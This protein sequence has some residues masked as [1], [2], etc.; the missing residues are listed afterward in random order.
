MPLSRVREAYFSC[1]ILQI[2]LFLGLTFANSENPHGS[3][4]ISCNMCHTT[5]S[6]E[7]LRPDIQ[8]D[9]QFQTDFPLDGKHL[10]VDCNE[11]HVSTVFSEV[12]TN[13]SSCHLD[14]HENQFDDN[15]QTCHSTDTWID[16]SEMV[17]FHDETSFPLTGVHAGL[18]CQI[19]H[20]DGN[21]VNVPLSCEG[22]HIAAFVNTD[23]PDHQSAGF[24]ADC[25]ICHSV[26]IQDWATP[27]YDHP[28]AFTLEQGHRDPDCIACHAAGTSYTLT[29]NECFSCHNQLFYAVDDPNHSAGN[30]NHDCQLCHSIGGWQPAEYD[31]NLSSFSLTGAHMA[32]ECA[33]CHLQNRFSG[34]PEHCYACHRAD[35]AAVVVPNHAA[36]DMGLDCQQ[37]HNTT[38]WRP[39]SF[40]H[41]QTEFVIDG[42]HVRLDCKLCHAGQ[43]YADTPQE[44]YG[45]HRTDFD[46]AAEPDHVLNQ[47]NQNCLICHTTSVWIPSTLDHAQTNFPLT[48]AHITADCAEC[49]V[50]DQY[51]GTPVDCWS[52]HQPAYKESTEPNHDEGM[53]DQDCAAC[54]TTEAWTPSTFNHDDTDYPLA[55]AHQTVDCNQCHLAGK[56]VGTP[57]DCYT[58]HQADYDNIADP[59]HS[60]PVFSHDCLACH[61]IDAW[62][63]AEFSH[64]GSEF[65]FNGGHEP[66]DCVSCHAG[67]SYN[68]TS[69]ECLACHQADFDE[70]G[71]PLH[72]VPEYDV[73]CLICHTIEA[74]TPA[75]FDHANS[76]FPLDGAHV[77]VDCASCHSNG[78]YNNTPATC[79][80]CH[81]EDFEEVSD[82]NHIDG[83]F[84]EDCL[85]CHNTSAWSPST[86][87]HDESDFQLTGAHIEATCAQCHI[88][89][90]FND[91]PSECYACH[92]ANYEQVV[93]PE[94]SEPQF[95]LDCAVCHT[96]T[97]WLTSTYDHNGSDF[98]LTG[99]HVDTDCAQ[100]HVNRQYDNTPADCYFCHQDAYERAEEPEH[101]QNQ[102]D[103][104]C[105]LCHS[106]EAWEPADFDH[107]DNDFPLTGAHTEVN[108]SDCHI[109][110][111]YNETPTDCYACHQEEYEDAND[112]DHESEGYPVDCLMCHATVDWDE[113][114]FDHDNDYFPIYRGGHRNRWDECNE[115]HVQEGNYEAFSCI[116]CHEHRREEA[117]DEHEDVRNYRYET[118]AC[119]ECHPNGEEDDDR[120][121]QLQP[122]KMKN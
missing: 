68:D 81:R 41:D 29:S 106:T 66:V 77:E 103:H 30:F 31:H 96:T 76:D 39:S 26:Q 50:Q 99:A 32:V 75:I 119:F 78:G 118:A 27:D 40:R 7:E 90:Q 60:E 5:D 34:T 61:T 22:C 54:H 80:G 122:M 9:H 70:V 82:P 73:N 105:K 28:D 102:F 62:N 74:W 58:C 89:G 3:L 107:D 72:T 104:D 71:D 97:D 86:F 100:C 115:C 117:D 109:A 67:G 8:F 121:F 48:G 36:S 110:G 114:N 45:C 87:D 43:T 52:C 84:D 13:C 69:V 44:C 116:D 35:Y 108:C 4:D 101:N 98:V 112:P 83:Q 42:S 57:N 46:A 25:S 94:H 18:D 24:E 47:L 91:L 49:H 51:S 17:L 37:C 20:S 55:G 92:R 23:N 59:R 12:Q 120:I 10:Q 53:F 1:V 2:P 11:C 14:V 38:A 33:M 65:P 64:K 111:N 93:D 63:P 19:C 85:Q 21:Y 88:D 113:A 79:V 95:D 6:W 16:I 15:C 56:F